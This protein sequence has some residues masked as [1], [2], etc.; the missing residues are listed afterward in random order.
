MGQRSSSSLPV[1]PQKRVFQT[2]LWRSLI[3]TP[4]IFL[5]Q[6]CWRL[7]KAQ[8]VQR[9]VGLAESCFHLVTLLK[10]KTYCTVAYTR[11]T[12]C[13]IRTRIPHSDVHRTRTTVQWQQPTTVWRICPNSSPPQSALSS[14]WT[15]RAILSHSSPTVIPPK[16]SN[17]KVR[18]IGWT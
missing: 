14:T 1:S 6:K 16:T 17:N 10:L 8:T 4:P 7:I 3:T 15:L 13:R 12:Q 11:T 5:F 2:F 9:R 18:D